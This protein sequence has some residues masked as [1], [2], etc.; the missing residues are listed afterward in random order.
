MSPRR[1]SLL[2]LFFNQF[3]QDAAGAGGMHK[4]IAIAFRA[5][6]N[7]IRYQPPSRGLQTLHGRFQILD[8]DSDMVQSWPSTRK[9]LRNRRIRPHRFQQFNARIAHRQHRNVNAFGWN[10]RSERRQVAQCFLV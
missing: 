3:Q 2:F 9:K 7:F 1:K 10:L 8:S 5:K 6:T 4:H